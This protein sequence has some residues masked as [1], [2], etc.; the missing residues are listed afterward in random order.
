MAR[1]SSVV[2][3]P[4]DAGRKPRCPKCGS[5]AR[6]LSIREKSNGYIPLTVRDAANCRDCGSFL[7]ATRAR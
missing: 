3:P 7:I 2:A 6:A 4:P 5:A 1:R